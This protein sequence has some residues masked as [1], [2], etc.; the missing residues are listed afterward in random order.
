MPLGARCNCKGR[1]NGTPTFALATNGPVFTPERLRSRT[2]YQF[3]DV[4][5]SSAMTFRFLLCFGSFAPSDWLQRRQQTR[6]LSI[7]S[8]PPWACGT[9]WSTSALFLMPLTW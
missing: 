4:G 3:W 7:R 9:M 5:R 1:G 2:F 8:A 6:T